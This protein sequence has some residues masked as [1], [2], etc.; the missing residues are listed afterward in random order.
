MHSSAAFATRESRPGHR[1]M[2]PSPRGV[3]RAVAVS[4]DALAQLD[5]PDP[6]RPA[7]DH[8]VVEL[9]SRAEVK[10]VWARGVGIR[11]RV[12]GA[13]IRRDG[14]QREV[15]ALVRVAV[16]RL[17]DRAVLAEHGSRVGVDLD[18]RAA[19]VAPV[20]V[21]RQPEQA[22]DRAKP[23][24]RAGRAPRRRRRGACRGRS[25]DWSCRG[26]PLR[27]SRWA[28]RPARAAAAA[29]RRARA[30]RRPAA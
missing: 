8:T 6:R 27:C 19:G 23:S 4:V 1:R 2:S 13:P 25:R 20:E 12:P 7:A 29:L 18:E 9:P 16:V 22:S 21:P 5:E 11:A 14:D 10:I 24:V 26:C 30:A 17:R 3:D 15:P 28:P